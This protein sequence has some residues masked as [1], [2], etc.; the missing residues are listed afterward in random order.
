MSS[1][2][3]RNCNNGVVAKNSCDD[4]GE[5]QLT[6]N[7]LPGIQGGK[8]GEHYHLTLEEKSKLSN[9]AGYEFKVEKGKR[10]GYTPLDGTAKVPLWHLPDHLLNPEPGPEG[11]PGLRGPIGPVGPIGEDGPDGPQGE[12]GLGINILGSDTVAN[13]LARVA[14]EIGDAWIATDTGTDSNGVPVAINDILRAS[15][16]N[17]PTSYANIGPI[18]GPEG[19]TGPIGP[20]GPIGVAATADAGTTTTLAPGVPATVTNT[21]DTSAAVFDFGIPEG[22]VGATGTPG[23]PGVDGLDGPQ[24]IQGEPGPSGIG[25]NILGSDTVANILAKVAVTIGD[26]WIATDTGTDSAGLP[27]VIDDILR[28]TNIL[29]PTHYANI[30][31]IIGP[32]GLTGPE[33]AQGIPG[34]AATVSAGTAT[35]LAAGTPPTVANSGTTA[36]AVFDFGIPAGAQG[37]QGIQG[38]PGA[39]SNVPGPAGGIGP[40]GPIGLPGVDGADGEKGDGWSGGSYDTGTGITTF[41]SDDGLGFATAD[42]RGG[43]GIEG[44]A[45]PQGIQ[46]IDG[47]AGPTGPASTVPGPEG[48]E[49]DPG[50]QGP[51]G[52]QGPAGEPVDVIDYL[53]SLDSDAAL[54]ANMGTKLNNEKAPIVSPVFQQ[55]AIVLGP[56]E[57]QEELGVTQ[58]S[59]NYYGLG[60]RRS[61]GNVSS[62]FYKDEDVNATVIINYTSSQL[63][64]TLFSLSGG[65]ASISSQTGAI[66]TPTEPEH[67]VNK[68][69][70]DAILLA[71][72]KRIEVIVSAMQ[73]KIDQLEN[74]IT[75]LGD[76]S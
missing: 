73:D 2:T 15:D 25:I 32:T 65:N 4:S 76:G 38:I 17:T 47:P 20:E 30:G 67:L 70:A 41:T 5:K 61:N 53:T 43:Q 18:L 58:G 7:T 31:P 1:Q 51:Q 72:E 9:E 66:L 62:A 3:P 16:I 42:L 27:V 33:G 13:I 50:N 21:G 59:Y 75:A 74:I 49:G 69:Y 56:L 68:T 36:A 55:D 24:G 39:D 23:T 14:V 29:T 19:P 37:V 6:H 46:G 64:E 52:P 22:L 11:P 57:V 71:A 28:A 45:G 54:S 10:D 40:E 26:S 63:V 34:V 48:P 8:E 44:P 35:G 12:P 60:C